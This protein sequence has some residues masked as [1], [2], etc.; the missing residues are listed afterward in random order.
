MPDGSASDGGPMTMRDGSTVRDSGP[1]TC[2]SGQH[3]CGGGCIDDLENLPE[4]GCRN[5]CGEACTT[6]PDG[7]AACDADGA[8]TV[9][10]EP[11]FTLVGTECVCSPRTCADMSAMCGAPDDGCGT[12]LDCGTCDAGGVCDAGLCSCPMDALEPND[13][14]LAVTTPLESIPDVS[15]WDMTYTTW[16]LHDAGD[17]DW[18]RFQVADSGVFDSNPDITVVLDNIP[19]GSNYDLAAYYV[20]D[21]GNHNSS[22]TSGMVDNSVGNGCASASSGTTSE[23]V[24]IAADCANGVSTDDAG[25]LWI[26]VTQRTFGGSCAPYR[27]RVHITS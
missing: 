11:P 2:T 15:D 8:C 20:C 22:C 19:S 27:L 12:P 26:H 9:G 16:T 6:P 3:R 14:R 25:A 7:V 13:S 23:Q 17:E 24:G 4:N 10:C 1:T 21:S 5:G 18:I